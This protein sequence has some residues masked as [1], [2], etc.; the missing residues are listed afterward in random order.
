MEST[1]HTFFLS[2]NIDVNKFRVNLVFESENRQILIK[3]I[4]LIK[5]LL[6]S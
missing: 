5:A 6:N 1:D 3:T 4:S 2:L